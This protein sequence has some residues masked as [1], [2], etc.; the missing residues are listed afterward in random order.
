MFLCVWKE[1][2]TDED[3][4]ISYVSFSITIAE[5]HGHVD[6]TSMCDSYNVRQRHTSFTCVTC[7]IGN[8]SAL[9][10]MC[11][12]HAVAHIHINAISV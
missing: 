9:L 11:K 10:Y 8:T 3:R 5:L 2:I 1:I 6:I 7:T 4:F 12:V